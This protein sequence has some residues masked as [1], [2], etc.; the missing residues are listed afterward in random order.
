MVRCDW[1]RPGGN[2]PMRALRSR[3]GGSRAGEIE[4][5]RLFCVLNLVKMPNYKLFQKQS[6]F[7]QNKKYNKI[8]TRWLK[9][10]VKLI[11]G[12]HWLVAKLLPTYGKAIAKLHVFAHFA[13]SFK[14]SV[15][16]VEVRGAPG[17][18]G[19]QFR[20]FVQPD[21]RSLKSLFS[22]FKIDQKNC[23]WNAH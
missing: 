13:G 21:P 15:S 16:Y 3:R 20:I 17:K 1:Q 19:L 2:Q 10:L 23:W 12:C 22:F 8:A 6:C 5:M 4:V 7:Y 9:A 11:V 14:F 18:S